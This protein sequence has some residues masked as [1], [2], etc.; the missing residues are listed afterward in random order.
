MYIQGTIILRFNILLLR[1][2]TTWYY[3]KYNPKTSQQGT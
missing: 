1:I 2:L 3:L